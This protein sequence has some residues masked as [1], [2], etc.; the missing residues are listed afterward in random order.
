MVYADK[1]PHLFRL[2]LKILDAVD[3]EDW[4]STWQSMKDMDLLRDPFDYYVIECSLAFVD[5]FVCEM[6]K[7]DDIMTLD[8]KNTAGSTTMLFQY[9]VEDD[10]TSL[11]IIMDTVRGK[12][13]MSSISNDR[14]NKK[15]KECFFSIGQLL[16]NFLFVMLAIKNTDK[17]TVKNTLSSAKNRVRKDA[18][19]YCETTTIKI[20]QI[21]ENYKSN[22]SGGGTIRPHMRRGHIRMQHY[23]KNNEE[24]KK[25]FIQPVFVNADEGW[26]AKQKNYRV[27]A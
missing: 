6:I 22:G 14:I 10:E 2:D 25:I 5:R 1:R 27:T 4:K 26:I 7:T 23:G 16:R 21:T 18:K 8:E 19:Y 9:K 24:T 13:V 20:G 15:T 12:I 3:P 11:D 17:Q